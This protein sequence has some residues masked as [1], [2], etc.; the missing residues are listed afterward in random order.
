MLPDPE[1]S[2]VCED[3][4]V[5]DGLWNLIVLLRRLLSGKLPAANVDHYLTDIG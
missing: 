1:Y 2:Q 3:E 4:L 5:T